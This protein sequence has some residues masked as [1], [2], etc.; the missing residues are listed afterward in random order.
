MAVINI[1]TPQNIEL[2]Y[3]LASLGDRM[4]ACI[5]DLLIIIAYCILVSMISSFT[6]GI[7]GDIIAL[8]YIIVFLPVTF[9]R[10]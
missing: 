10:F 9:T 2:E 4:V 6:R 5:I 8:F 1:T 7:S 3:E